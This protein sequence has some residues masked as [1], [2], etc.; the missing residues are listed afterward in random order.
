MNASIRVVRDASF[1]GRAATL[2]GFME[3]A[4]EGRAYWQDM[5]VKRY[6]REELVK[7]E[8]N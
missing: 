7:W 6:W 4:G 2:A 1:N 8:R 5:R 3:E